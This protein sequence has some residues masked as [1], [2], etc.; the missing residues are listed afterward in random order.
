MRL[1]FVTQNDPIYVLPFF[2]EFFQGYSNE[3]S[4]DH[5]LVSRVMGKRSRVKLLRELVALYTLPGLVRLGLRLLALKCL[6]ALPAGSRPG[7]FSS[8]KHLSSTYGVS[9]KEIGNPNAPDVIAGIR[10]AQP[11]VLIS[12]ASPYI[13][14]E[15]LLSVPRKGCINIHHAP[16]PRYKGMM[17]TFWQ[18]LHGE[19]S[20]GITVHYMAG[21]LDEGA[22]LLQD[23]LEIKPGESLDSLIRRS[24]RYGAHC[25]ARVLRHI[26]AGTQR[27]IVLDQTQGSYFTFPN[28][29][30]MREFH[31]R[32]FRAI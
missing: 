15:T 17:P 16:L 31:R 3:F 28:R 7:R 29:E 6:G 9:Y 22:A 26:V 20:V 13:F 18:M 8:I 21:K 12:V 24:K 1:T 14:K 5:I 4:V 25:I 19:R 27:P 11:D 32:G 23:R 10:A 2:E 30:Q